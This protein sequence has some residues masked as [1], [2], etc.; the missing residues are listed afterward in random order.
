[1]MFWLLK[2]NMEKNVTEHIGWKVFY[3][4]EMFPCGKEAIDSISCFQRE[5]NYGDWSSLPCV[6]Q[7][8]AD[9]SGL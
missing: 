9:Q 6:K 3:I 5:A 4:L 8:R 7:I 1:M 2:L